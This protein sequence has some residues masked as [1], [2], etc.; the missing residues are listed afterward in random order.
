MFNFQKFIY[1][2]NYKKVTTNIGCGLVAVVEQ[3]KDDVSVTIKKES[4]Y[5]D[6]IRRNCG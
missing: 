5:E 4:Q 6:D 2:K 3:S 1:R